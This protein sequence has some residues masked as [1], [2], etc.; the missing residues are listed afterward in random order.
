M[1]EEGLNHQDLVTAS[2][3]KLED[4]SGQALGLNIEVTREDLLV[5]QENLLGQSVPVE[6]ASS[7]ADALVPNTQSAVT[8]YFIQKEVYKRVIDKKISE[9]DHLKDY[10]R[11]RVLKSLKHTLEDAQKSYEESTVTEALLKDGEA[12]KM[13]RDVMPKAVGDFGKS[14]FAENATGS[15]INEI[16]VTYILEKQ[17]AEGFYKVLPGVDRNI[18]SQAFGSAFEQVSTD[19]LN[20]ASSTLV[21]GSYAQG[22]GLAL[23]PSRTE[24]VV[25][26]EPNKTSKEREL[27]PAVRLIVE[28]P[29][30]FKGTT[31][32]EKSKE[33]ILHAASLSAGLELAENDYDL[34][35][36]VYPNLF[37]FEGGRVGYG[38]VEHT[39]LKSISAQVHFSRLISPLGL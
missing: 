30:V 7:V 14:F 38:R 33:A 15:R 16:D 29:L 26:R 32:R 35:E 12:E 17:M 27:S 22:R 37:P 4:E 36:E 23:N 34:I 24:S 25:L 31:F 8:N 6:L 1:T 13:L 18:A 20:L 2:I 21:K 28:T 5:V 9:A 3:N 10:S 11:S 39:M 19:Y